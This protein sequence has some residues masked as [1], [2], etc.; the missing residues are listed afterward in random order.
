MQMIIVLSSNEDQMS[1]MGAEHSACAKE[2]VG[3]E[4]QNADHGSSPRELGSEAAAPPPRPGVLLPGLQ[5]GLISQ[6]TICHLF[7]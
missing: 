2:V 6:A 5:R 3:D 7:G 4:L 1:H